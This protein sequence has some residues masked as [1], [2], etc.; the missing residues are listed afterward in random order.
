MRFEFSPIIE[1][2]YMPCEF[3][4]VE[5][6]ARAEAEFIHY[7]AFQFTADKFTHWSLKP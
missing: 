1:T 7:W 5:P 3:A 6:D 4:V 2:F